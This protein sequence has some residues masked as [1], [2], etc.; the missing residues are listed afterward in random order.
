MR[1]ARSP[2]RQRFRCLSPRVARVAMILA[3]GFAADYAAYREAAEESTRNPRTGRKE[4][5]EAFCE[6]GSSLWTDYDNICGGCEDG[7]TMGDAK[8][9]YARAIDEAKYLVELSDDMHRIMQM[10]IRAGVEF[11]RAAYVEMWQAKTGV[12][13]TEFNPYAQ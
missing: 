8:Q 5:R 10:M 11:D 3:N 6:H 9:R 1:K 12:A 2:F 7:R 13:F 4:W